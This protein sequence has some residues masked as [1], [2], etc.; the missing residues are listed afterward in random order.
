MYMYMYLRSPRYWYHHW[1]WRCQEWVATPGWHGWLPILI[2]TLVINPQLRTWEKPASGSQSI[3]ILSI[4]FLLVTLELMAEYISNCQCSI[5]KDVP[6]GR[7]QTFFKEGQM[8]PP[9]PPPKRNCAHIHVFCM[10]LW[11][12]RTRVCHT[13]LI[14][15]PP[16]NQCCVTVY[17]C[18]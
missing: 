10:Y 7:G 12:M 4:L 3:D 14:P 16:D 5:I 18:Y 11:S 9:L 8:P 15:S 13:L 17:E 1:N 2:P 6:G